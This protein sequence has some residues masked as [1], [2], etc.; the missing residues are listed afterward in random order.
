LL[1]TATVNVAPFAAARTKHRVAGRLHHLGDRRT[2]P[3]KPKL[4]FA[5]KITALL[6][7]KKLSATISSAKLAPHCRLKQIAKLPLVREFFTHVGQK[8][9]TGVD[10]FVTRRA[11]AAGFRAWLFGRAT[12]HRHTRR[13][14]ISLF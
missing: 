14:W 6:K 11:V 7:S 8:K 4:P 1:G 5:A 13:R 10:Y 3:A 9:P 2:L 12:S